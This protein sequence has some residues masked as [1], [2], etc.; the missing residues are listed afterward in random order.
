M[1]SNECL[2]LVIV[3]ILILT[4]LMI[5]TKSR[6]TSEEPVA[7]AVETAA[8]ADTAPTPIDNVVQP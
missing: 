4:G 5:V 8:S 1:T 2:A 6:A 3:F 7:P